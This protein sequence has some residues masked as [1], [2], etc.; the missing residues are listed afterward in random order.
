MKLTNGNATFVTGLWHIKESVKRDLDYYF[1]RLPETLNMLGNSNIVFFYAGE[2]IL[3]FVEKNLKT[4][5]FKA[6]KIDVADLP[7]YELSK[8]YLQSCKNQDN[9]HLKRV[10]KGKEKGLKHYKRDYKQSNE[11]VFRK[12]FTVW[13]SK[14]FLIEST[15]QKNPYNTDFFAWTD[16]SISRFFTLRKNWNFMQQAYSSK[17]IYHYHSDMKYYG[18]RCKLNASF[19]LGHKNKLLKLISLYRDQLKKSKNS[20]Y[21]HDEE[22]LLHLL[23]KENSRLFRYIDSSQ[24]RFLNNIWHWFSAEKHNHSS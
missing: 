6:I 16:A 9:A 20:N 11:D 3:Q 19:M 14:L 22:T 10:S 8:F 5:N 1:K 18:E 13:T 2:N 24:P 12:L 21:A 4:N 17:F 7:T 15:I 23:H